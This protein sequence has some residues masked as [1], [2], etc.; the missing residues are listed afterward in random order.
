MLRGPPPYS[1]HR[2]NPNLHRR[3]GP[4]CPAQ[5]DQ[6]LRHYPSRLRLAPAA[7]QKNRTK[8]TL[9]VENLHYF[10]SLRKFTEIRSKQQK[11][12]H[13]RGLV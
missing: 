9:I 12:E 10:K 1:L 13:L 2:S 5:L 7:I 3:P 6:N 8:K 4:S 11:S